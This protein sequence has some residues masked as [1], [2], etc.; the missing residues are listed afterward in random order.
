VQVRIVIAILFLPRAFRYIPKQ[1]LHSRVSLQA[2]RLLRV[3]VY[4]GIQQQ[5][6]RSVGCNR[7]CVRR[8]RL[9]SN[10]LLALCVEMRGPERLDGLAK[11]CAI[12]RVFLCCG[13]ELRAGTL[14]VGGMNAKDI[15]LA[16]RVC[17][18]IVTAS[19]RRSHEDQDTRT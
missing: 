17:S 7:C 2:R 5:E 9:R 1:M 14:R 10:S 3:E 8:P 16:C 13:N 19:I 6:S 4:S 11:G 15:S 18:I 12:A